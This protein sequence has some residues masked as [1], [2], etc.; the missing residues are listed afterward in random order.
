MGVKGVPSTTSM[1]DG[2][3]RAVEVFTG[4]KIPR[5]NVQQLLQDAVG[6]SGLAD[7]VRTLVGPELVQTIRAVS[8]ALDG[9][10]AA[11]FVAQTAPFVATQPGVLFQVADLQDQVADAMRQY[12]VV[13]DYA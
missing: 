5:A 13:M 12:A 11:R 2:S 6:L 1:N 3:I 10:T 7:R 8:N 4:T 9:Q